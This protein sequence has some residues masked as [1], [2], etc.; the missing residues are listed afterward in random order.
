MSMTPLKSC[1]LGTWPMATNTPAHSST[2]SALVLTFFNRTPV[3]LSCFTSRTSVTTESQIGLILG[4]AERPLGH[5]FGGA[6]R[7]AAMHQVNDGAEP[8]E[9]HRLLAGRIP[10]AHDDQRLVAKERQRAV[11]GGAVGHALVLQ[12]ALAL[13]AQVPMA[14]PAGDDDG[15]GLDRFAIHGQLERLPGQVHRL[16]GAE[17]DAR[18]E[19]LG[20]L[21]HARHQLVAVNAFREAGIILDH[22][23][24]GQQAAR[25]RAGQHQRAQVRPRGVKRGRQAGAAGTDDDD[26]FHRDAQLSCRQA[27][28]AADCVGASGDVR[29]VRSVRRR[30]ERQERQERRSVRSVGASGAWSVRA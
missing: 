30:Q 20:L 22:G 13:Q 4:W 15:L 16:D 5:D 12:L 17:L 27:W 24:G 18:A 28:Q 7:V 9:I 2:L 23:G 11:A 3:T 26:F 14:G 1:V 10:A 21:L 8:R 29:S 25:V 6:Q 19:A